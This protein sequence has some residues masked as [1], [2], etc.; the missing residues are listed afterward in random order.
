MKITESQLRRIVRQTII[1]ENRKRVLQESVMQKL[2]SRPMMLFSLMMALSG[3]TGKSIPPEATVPNSKAAETFVVG[4]A[5]EVAEK[6]ETFA[7]AVERINKMDIPA[8]DKKMLIE[9][10][11]FLKETQE[12]NKSIDKAISPMK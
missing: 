3:C 10:L 11:E 9:H 8:E 7:E 2:A 5:E 4:A 1:E 12:A 6:P